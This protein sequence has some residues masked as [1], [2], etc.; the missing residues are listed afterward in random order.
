[1][2]I[3]FLCIPRSHR[4]I[5]YILEYGMCP[6]IFFLSRGAEAEKDYKL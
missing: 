3:I 1:M 2:Q 6:P 5:Y 4:L